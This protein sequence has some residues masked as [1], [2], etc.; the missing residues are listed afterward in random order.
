M[1]FAILH[2][3]IQTH[4]NCSD[5]MHLHEKVVKYHGGHDQYVYILSV[6]EV[7]VRH[8]YRNDGVL[9]KCSYCYI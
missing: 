6:R 1:H 3:D 7:F 8:F 5:C 2:I 9:Q 4:S